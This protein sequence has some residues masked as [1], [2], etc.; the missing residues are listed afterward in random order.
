M[1]ETKFQVD[2]API[3]CPVKHTYSVCQSY[4]VLGDDV[5]QMVRHTVVLCTY[6]SF[7][8]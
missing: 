2:F 4:R 3:F 1:H 6:C 5:T 8:L 7:L